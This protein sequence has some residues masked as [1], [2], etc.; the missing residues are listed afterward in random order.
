MS[1]LFLRCTCK[2]GSR[3]VHQDTI[4]NLLY[5]GNELLFYSLFGITIF[6]V[7]D[8]EL[9]HTQEGDDHYEC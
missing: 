8:F 2:F 4:V 6:E 7:L 9:Q 3:H 1:I 5:F